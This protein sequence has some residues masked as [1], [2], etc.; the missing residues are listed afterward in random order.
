MTLDE[1]NQTCFA[2]SRL[3]IQRY[4]TSFSLGTRVFPPKVRKAIAA[5]YGFVR[6]A[7]EIVDTFHDYD[8][9]AILADFKADT[10]RALSDGISTNP[11]LHAFQHVVQEY[12]VDHRYVEAFL[13]SMEMD[14]TLTTYSQAQYEEYIYG[15]AEVIGLMCLKIFCQDTPGAFAEL[16]QP[17]QQLGSAFQKVNFLRDIRSDLETRGRIYLPGINRRE[18]INEAAKQKIEAE[19]KEE[20]SRALDGIRKLPQFAK[21]AVYSTYLYYQTLF[22]KLQQQNIQ[23]LLTRRVRVNN[24]HKILLFLCASVRICFRVV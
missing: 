12:D 21:L 23:G 22:V 9:A 14:L 7:D 16:A 1:Y 15:S 10:Y 2:V 11:V 5:I 20:F 13:K 8:K 19:I 24:F 3:I 4:S 18:Q 6:L 17:A